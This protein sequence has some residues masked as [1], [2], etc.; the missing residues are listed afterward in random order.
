MNFEPSLS[1]STFYEQA[2]GWEQTGEARFETKGL[3]GTA[4]GRGLMRGPLREKFPRQAGS[5]IFPAS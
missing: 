3:V 5:S 4:M 1:A 2:L